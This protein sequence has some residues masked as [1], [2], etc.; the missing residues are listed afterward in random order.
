MKVADVGEF[1]LIEL[2]AQTIREFNPADLSAHAGAPGGAVPFLPAVLVGIGDDTAAWQVESPV[3]LA[4]TDTLVQD[5]HFS[6]A[7][8]TW[9]EIGWKS[10]AVNL[11]DIAAMG[12]LPRYAL[13][14]LGLPG[15]LEV[16]DV[17]DLYRG[18]LDVAWRFGVAVVGGDMVRAREVF[19]TV[20]LTGEA[21]PLPGSR[22]D[23]LLRSGA[24]P[25]DQLAI[26]GFLGSSAA[27]L[28][29]LST[30][31]RI[32]AEGAA[33]LREA[34][35]RPVPRVREGLVVRREGGLSAMDISDGLLADLAKMCAASG[36]GA[37]IAV[38][39]LPIHPFVA[40]CFPAEAE[41]LA[42]SGGEDYELLFAAPADV[43][44]RV[45]AAV[46][47]PVSVIGEVTEDKTGGVRVL[48]RH[49]QVVQQRQH[50]WDHFRRE[51]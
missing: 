29:V 6:L 17:V 11:S 12:G 36:A 28:K 20:A 13:V 30:G 19:L 39:R 25:G 47:V 3:Q 51:R 44:A 23:L 2:V 18:M 42:L 38:D 16:D 24:K 49:G 32:E 22:T 35:L 46:E 9:R 43:V 50:G 45:R 1:R 31:R 15:D 26:T 10:L 5:V 14:T 7:F 21:V 48:D 40:A 8:A 34:H 27:G 37:N 33:G 4:T 41:T